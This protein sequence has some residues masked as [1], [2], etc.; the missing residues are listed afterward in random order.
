[1]KPI[2]VAVLGSTGMLGHTVFKTL[3]QDPRLLV[4]GISRKSKPPFDALDSIWKLDHVL[5]P[6]VDYVINCAGVIWQA[7]NPSREE[8]FRVNTL[9][10]RNLARLVASRGVRLIHVSTDC[11]FSGTG[12]G[13]HTEIDVPD[14][15]D[16]YGLSKLLGEPDDAMVLRT[17][18][19]GREMTTKR[20][21]LE[22]AIA[23]SGKQVNGYTNHIWNGVT[24]MAYAKIC[25]EIMCQDLY[26]YGVHHLHSEAKVSKYELLTMINDEMRLCMKINPVEAP[27]PVDRSLASVKPLCKRLNIPHIR[28]LIT[29]IGET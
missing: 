7:K 22:W 20:S 9:F 1:M 2:H 28:R 5:S 10:P 18:V 19:I 4:Q 3:S 26:A 25:S 14:A 27:D 15:T 8:T 29:Q 11:V 21:L 12:K 6:H 24:S 23:N 17:S 16:D 13:D